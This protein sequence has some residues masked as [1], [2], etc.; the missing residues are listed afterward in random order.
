MDG[1]LSGRRR[2]PS[3]SVSMAEMGAPRF[4]RRRATALLA[5]GFVPM[6]LPRAEPDERL[7]GRDAGYPVGTSSDWYE[8]RHRVGSWSAMDAVRGFRTRVVA[9]G[10][11]PM[12]LT[13]APGAPTIR[14]RWDGASRALDDYLE[15]RPTTGLL[16]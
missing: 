6:R 5:L 15:R 1:G 13:P 9:A 8:A 3:Q 16:V 14:Y 10:A 12:V 4:D 2:T 11:V 7:L